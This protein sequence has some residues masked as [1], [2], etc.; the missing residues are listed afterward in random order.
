MSYWC[1][2]VNYLLILNPDRRLE[3]SYRTCYEI[4]IFDMNFC[5]LFLNLAIHTSRTTLILIVRR[6]ERARGGGN[7]RGAARTNNGNQISCIKFRTR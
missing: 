6:K 2:D 5:L 4:Q 7:E 1:F 3:I